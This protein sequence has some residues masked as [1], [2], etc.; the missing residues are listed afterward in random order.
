M[1]G[2]GCLYT[3]EASRKVRSRCFIR[4]SC[5]LGGP[6]ATPDPSEAMEASRLK[7]YEAGDLSATTPRGP[8]SGCSGT[9]TARAILLKPSRASRPGAYRQVR[10]LLWGVLIKGNPVRGAFPTSWV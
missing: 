6:R 9:G 1:M 7:K 4:M 3:Y 10:A 2:S 5:I 8:R